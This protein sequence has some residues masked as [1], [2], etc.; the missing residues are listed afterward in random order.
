MDAR[1]GRAGSR[2]GGSASKYLGVDGKVARR[3]GGLLRF[4]ETHEGDV[5][6]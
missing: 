6:G 4:K 2:Y 1:V 5:V 3:Q